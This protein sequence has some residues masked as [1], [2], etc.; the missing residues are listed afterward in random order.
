MRRQRPVQY[1]DQVLVRMRRQDKLRLTEVAHAEGRTPTDLARA[2]IGTWLNSQSGAAVD[3]RT[4][5]AA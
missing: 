4:A 2:I 3:N 1:D 5:A